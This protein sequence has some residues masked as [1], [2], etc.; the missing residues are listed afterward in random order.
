MVATRDL[1]ILL[2]TVND[3]VYATGRGMHSADVAQIE[4][5]FSKLDH[6][7]VAVAL[8]FAFALAP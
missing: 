1:A 2:W 5:S 3:P 8:A 6:L 7:S 4:I